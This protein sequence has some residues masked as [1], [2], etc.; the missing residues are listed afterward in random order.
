ME[1]NKHVIVDSE[2]CIGCGD[3]ISVCP[4]NSLEIID[5]KAE[6]VNQDCFLCDHCAS[7][8]PEKAI[9]VLDMDENNLK[10]QN[11]LSKVAWMI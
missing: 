4:T 9:K 1:D 8:C 5:Q 3:C 6:V 11:Q 7:G 2:L 10:L